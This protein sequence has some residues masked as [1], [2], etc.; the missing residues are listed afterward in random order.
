[1]KDI[2]YLL[3]NIAKNDH[4]HAIFFNEIDYIKQE[5]G[6]L[7]KMETGKINEDNIDKDIFYKYNSLGF[8]SDEFTKNHEGN[9]ILFAG[10]SETEGLGGNLESCWP[11][12]VYDEISKNEKTSGFYNLGRAMWG[13]QNIIINVLLYIQKYNKPDNIFILFPN[14]GRQLIW[15]KESTQEF[16]AEI[17]NLFVALANYSS[18]EH[19]PIKQNKITIREQRDLFINFCLSMKL[20]EKI[21]KENNINLYWSTWDIEDLESFKNIKIFNN[22][23]ET[24][25]FESYIKYNFEEFTETIKNRKDWLRKRDGHNGYGQHFIWKNN[26][27]KA[28]YA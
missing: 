4:T 13:W 1:M 19:M 25:K 8:R 10:C 24:F 16:N 11:K 7:H 12:M 2:D 15:D 9:H 26:F 18:V 23:I 17:Y 21:C 3:Y 28:Y 27:L 6:Y 22:L 5:D 20:L 14:I